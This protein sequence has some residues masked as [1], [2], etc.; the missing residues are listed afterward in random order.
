MNIAR[1]IAALLV[2]AFAACTEA[3]SRGGDGRGRVDD[4]LD[5][6]AGS[7][8]GGVACLSSGD[9]DGGSCIGGTCC[10]TAAFSPMPKRTRR[11]SD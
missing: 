10:A 5:L 9:C 6:S 7:D 2:L 1:V 4:E 8:D 3:N 11:R